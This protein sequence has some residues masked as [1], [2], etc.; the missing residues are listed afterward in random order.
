M[1]ELERENDELRQLLQAGVMLA[2]A[3]LAGDDVDDELRKWIDAVSGF[4]T[5]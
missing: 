3:V 1:D 4:F 2:E 5:K